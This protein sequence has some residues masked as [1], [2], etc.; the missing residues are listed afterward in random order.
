M[1][2]Q[3]YVMYSIIPLIVVDSS[4][5]LG[6][7]HGHDVKHHRVWFIETRWHRWQEVY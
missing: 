6:Y 2:P 1:I 3:I 4:I 7:D 5:P